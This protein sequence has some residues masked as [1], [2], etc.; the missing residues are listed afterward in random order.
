MARGFLTLR[1]TGAR[2]ARIRAW[3]GL[4]LLASGCASL[5][6]TPA[7]DLAWSRWTTCHP[8]AAGTEITTVQPDGRISFWYADGA[9]R[10]AMHDCLVQL[11]KEGPVLPDP[12][13]ELRP[14]AGGGGGGG[15][16]G[17]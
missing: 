4:G 11:A 15:G 6:N 7:Q 2:V 3:V 12:V 13:A 5:S 10:Q 8:R 9:E 17:M 1:R 14:G 16:G